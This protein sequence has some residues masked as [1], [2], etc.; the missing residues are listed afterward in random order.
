MTG[1]Y[2]SELSHSYAIDHMG[3][4]KRRID[5]C[6][7]IYVCEGMQCHVL[8]TIPAPLVHVSRPDGHP[9]LHV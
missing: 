3:A 7:Y 5:Q 4:N 8:E 1:V 9:M 6:I 2:V